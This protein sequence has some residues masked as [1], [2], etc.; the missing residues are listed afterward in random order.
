[1][2]DVDEAMAAFGLA[3]YFSTLDLKINYLAGACTGRRQRRK[4]FYN[5]H[6][7]EIGYAQRYVT[8]AP[9]WVATHEGKALADLISATGA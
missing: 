8:R 5:T 7:Q 2:P 9:D 6:G 3:Q 1:M 4:S